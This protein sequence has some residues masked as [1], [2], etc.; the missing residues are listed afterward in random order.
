MTDSRP[1]PDRCRKAS[2]GSKVLSKAL[3]NAPGD[4]FALCHTGIGFMGDM[5]WGT[6]VCLFH[7]TPRTRSIWRFAISRRD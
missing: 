2:S 1:I 4:D 3:A 6:H 7:E 5:P